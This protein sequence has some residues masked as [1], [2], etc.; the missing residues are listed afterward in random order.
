[1][2]FVLAIIGIGASGIVG[3]LLEPTLRPVLTHQEK[4]APEP[5]TDTPAP[6][7]TPTPTEK[8]PELTFDYTKLQ[9]Q[10]LPAKVTLK[11]EAKATA[12]GETDA[13]P[14]PAGTKVKPL[15]IEGFELIFSVLGTAQGKIDVK[16]TDLVEQLIAN[17]PPPVAVVTEPEPEAPPVVAVKPE[18]EPE[19]E[20]MIEAEPEPAPA[21]ATT[22]EPAAPATATL[23]PDGIIALMKSS[24]ESKQISE[25]SL[26]QVNDWKAGDE[27]TI[28]G[29]S[30]QT[31]IASYQAETIFGTKNIQAKALIKGG[32]VVR[33][34]WPTSG[35][36]IQ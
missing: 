20:P 2:K 22:P 29:E 5:I 19:P 18:P 21:V 15:R 8:S 23:G 7:P 35:L 24:L 30:Y 1:M 28:D 4:T 12:A 3:Y 32:K 36:E 6:T 13:V 31:G 16:Q 27:E 33:W 17:P 10:Q 26:D 9:P 25:F 34:I 14:L 11:S